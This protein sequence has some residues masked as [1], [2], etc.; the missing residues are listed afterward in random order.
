MYKV[1]G[2]RSTFIFTRRAVSTIP[3]IHNV[4]APGQLTCVSPLSIRQ[5]RTQG[6]IA[7]KV[8]RFTVIDILA[9]PAQTSAIICATD[10][11]LVPIDG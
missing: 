2:K 4:F 3:D 10:V 9:E 7:R 8:D 5:P 11:E 6:S 1:P